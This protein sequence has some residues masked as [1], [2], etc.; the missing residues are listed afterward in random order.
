[1]SDSKEN[2]Q[3][4]SVESPKT[5]AH[6]VA[7]WMIFPLINS[8]VT[9]NH[10]TSLR[11]ISGVAAAACF[12]TG[13]YLWLLAG[14]LLFALSMLCDRA[15]G[16]LARLSNKSS[17]LGH[18]YDLICDMLV[19]IV[20]FIGIGYGL[21]GD[22]G[23]NSWALS[24]GVV[25]GICIGLIFIIVFQFHRRGS[26]PSIVFKYPKGFD[27]DDSLFIIP[28]LACLDLMMP[29][30]IAAVL[31]SPSFLLLSLWQAGRS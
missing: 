16:E 21:R 4:N 6:S 2:S 8:W 27:L 22:A 14:G 17:R 10:I 30:L 11:L 24:M 3:S 5:Y 19:N 18:W 26:H 29:L 12:A 28:I 7:R 20:V 13:S 9:P 25:S 1:M 15:D 23:L 31:V